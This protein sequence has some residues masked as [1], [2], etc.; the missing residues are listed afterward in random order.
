MVTE[1]LDGQASGLDEVP[2][3]LGSFDR[4]TGVL[5]LM[6]PVRVYQV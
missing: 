4:W 1:R 5:D 2:G 3:F 6:S